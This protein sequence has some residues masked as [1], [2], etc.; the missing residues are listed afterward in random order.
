[1]SCRA[2]RPDHNGE[3]LNCDEPA[4]AHRDDARVRW[5]GPTWHAP[6]NQ[7]CI[8]EPTPVGRPCLFC[9]KLIHDG[10]QGVLLWFHG[11]GPVLLPHREPAHLACF[12]HDVGVDV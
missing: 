9:K 8:E 6:I 2:Y 12:L 5:F 11:V 1:M 3:C 10:D 4:D 7:T